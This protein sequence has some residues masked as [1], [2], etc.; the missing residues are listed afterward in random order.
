M[1]HCDELFAFHAERPDTDDWT[2]H[3]QNPIVRSPVKARNAGMI[4]APDGGVIR[5]AQSQ[6]FQHYGKGVSLNRIEE[7]TP[8]AYRESDGPVHYPNFLRKPFASMHR[9]IITADILCSTLHLW[10]NKYCKALPRV[11]GR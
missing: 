1:S 4:L 3:A 2:P 11:A 6:G 10:N 7:L 9:G 8:H 5:C